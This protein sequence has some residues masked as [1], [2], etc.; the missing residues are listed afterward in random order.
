ML[1]AERLCEATETGAELLIT[2]CPKCQTHFRCA[3]VDKGE[4]H[5]S[6]PEI[7]VMDLA[8]LVADAIEK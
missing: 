2:A 6:I 8:N 1:R 7:E 3:M 4:E 5:R